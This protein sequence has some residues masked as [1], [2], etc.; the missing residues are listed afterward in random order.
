VNL[1]FVT[2]DG[3]SWLAFEETLQLDTMIADVGDVEQGVLGQGA[4]D[5]E[6][7]ALNVAVLG[8]LRD[9]GDVCRSRG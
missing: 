5:A 6:E 8:V 3:F 4:L 7:E 2:T 9:I 1:P